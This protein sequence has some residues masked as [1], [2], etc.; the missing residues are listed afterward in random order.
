MVNSLRARNIDSQT[1][2]P[3]LEVSLKLSQP[4]PKR[5]IDDRRQAIQE[6]IIKSF[7][8]RPRERAHYVEVKGT[9]A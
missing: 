5:I 1:L 3:W 2:M 6:Y 7:T 8:N 9:W 4:I